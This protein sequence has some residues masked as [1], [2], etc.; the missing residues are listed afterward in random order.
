MKRE[1]LIRIGSTF[2]GV[3]TL[4]V[5]CSEEPVFDDD[6]DDD[7][8]GGG[9][10][11]GVGTGSGGGSFVTSGAGGP[12]GATATGTGTMAT[13]TIG[14][15]GSG[16]TTT[17]ATSTGSGMTSDCQMACTV[18]YQCGADNRGALCPNFVPGVVSQSDFLDGPNG[19]D[20]CVAQCLSTPALLQLVDPTNCP[21]TIQTL[22]TV[23]SD[24]AASCGGN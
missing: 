18:V 17:S 21:A 22:S 10:G 24:F 5:A 7:D 16:T 1:R 13:T 8:D 14:A 2:L 3:A 20:G 15:T 9:A 19:N 6:D 4:I 23:I 11:A 12:G